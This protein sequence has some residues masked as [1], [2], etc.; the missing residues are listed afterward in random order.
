MVRTCL[1]IGAMKAGTTTLF[2][3][4][5]QHP[6]VCRPVLK[7][8]EFFSPYKANVVEDYDDLWKVDPDLHRYRVEAS[9]G[10]TKARSAGVPKIIQEYGIEPK[11]IYIL[12]DPFARIESHYNY[13]RRSVQMD[14]S[15]RITDHHLIK[16]SD[17]I[18]HVENFL[19]HFPRESL[20]LLDFDRLSRNPMAVAHEVFQFLGLDDG[21]FVPIGGVRNPTKHDMSLAEV[22]LRRKLRSRFPKTPM[23]LRRIGS[24]VLANFPAQGSKVY[25][26]AHQRDFVYSCLAPGMGRLSGEFGVDVRKWGF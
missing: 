17:Y 22:W 19:A 14:W 10:Y 24:N 6:Q 20:L 7:E 8:P 13:M 12:R 15:S 11:L 5:C 9:T 4:I 26:S 25:L 23:A 1:V 18:S 2:E 3:L 21:G 16:A